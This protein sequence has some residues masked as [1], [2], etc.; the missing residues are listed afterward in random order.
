MDDRNAPDENEKIIE[1]LRKII[2]T[3]N[4]SIFQLKT[5]IDDLPGDVY[6]KDKEGTWLGLNKHCLESL[7]KMGFI[8][9][10][11][12]QEVV[13][14]TDYQLFDREV[15]AGYRANDMEVMR[16]QQELIIEEDT[17]LPSKEHVILHSTKKTLYDK[18]GLV[19]G[20]VGNT[21]DI[22]YLKN[23]EIELKK[24]KEQAEA[25]NHAKS[26]FIANM[27]HDIRTPLAGVIGLSEV[28]KHSLKNPEEREKA[29]LLHDSGE[30]LLHMLND[31]LDDVQAE[32]IAACRLFLRN[33]PGHPSPRQ[34]QKQ[35]TSMPP[36]AL[37]VL[38]PLDFDPPSGLKICAPQ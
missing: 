2:A 35:A 23:I 5:L 12:E 18:E 36:A 20:I 27:S 11:N 15:A 7:F 24:A 37:A 8:K 1:D 14:K 9:T 26:A 30:E 34:G 31:I 19:A 28:L 25:A 21:I 17:L 16:K 29:H 38:V 22:T 6:W 33:L 3:Q 4:N 32:Y 10:C 13:G